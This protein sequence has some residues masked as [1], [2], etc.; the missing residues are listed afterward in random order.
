[1]LFDL[2]FDEKQAG[3]VS[4]ERDREG[5]AQ[6]DAT[7][8]SSRLDLVAAE[9]NPAHTFDS[10][11]GFDHDNF[12]GELARVIAASGSAGDVFNPLLLVG[13]PGRGKSHLLSAIANQGQRLAVRLLRG[14]DLLAF[15]RS[16]PDPPLATQLTWFVVDAQLLLLDDVDVCLVNPTIQHV[17]ADV[18]D[19]LVRSGRGVVMTAAS[20]PRELSG[21]VPGLTDRLTQTVT[22]RLGERTASERRL[23]I[24]RW[25]PDLPESLVE[26]LVADA[27]LDL[28][29]VKEL[30]TKTCALV[31]S[32]GPDFVGTEALRRLIAVRNTS[33]RLSTDLGVG[34]SEASAVPTDPEEADQPFRTCEIDTNQLRLRGIL[35]PAESAQ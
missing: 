18:I 21:L 15:Q 16:D 2:Q 3:Q 14:E 13:G 11:I 24:R 1:M 9:P 5:A 27:G 22:I 29:R 8:R 26:T 7:E 4:P 19:K 17:L 20:N 25:A 32:H 33:T 30:A 34:R 35:P 6:S 12:V 31:R 23:L 10:L 28:G